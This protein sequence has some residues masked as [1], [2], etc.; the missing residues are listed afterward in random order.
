MPKIRFT[1]SV[2]HKIKP[3]GDKGTWFSDTETKG[4]Q[5][6]VGTSGKNTWYVHYRRPDTRKL[7]YHKIGDADLFSVSQARESARAFLVGV[8]QGDTPWVKP[9]VPAVSGKTTLEAFL[10]GSYGP[11]VGEYR[12]SAPL[13]SVALSVAQGL[14]A[15]SLC[16]L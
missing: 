9:E 13:V 12:R 8:A 2:L 15:L 6:W 5:L 10:E 3:L 4:L 16:Y 14:V 7:A 1:T 11:W